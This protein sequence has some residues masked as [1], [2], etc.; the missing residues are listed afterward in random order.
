MS[1]CSVGE[2][3]GGS[4]GSVFSTG[5]RID[6][7]NS[8]SAQGFAINRCGNLQELSFPRSQLAESPP[9][10][11]LKSGTTSSAKQNP[12]RGDQ[13]RA[14]DGLLHKKGSAGSKFF[15]KNEHTKSEWVPG[16]PRGKGQG[17]EGLIGSQ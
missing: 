3:G 2:C 10:F 7:F 15:V 1:S 6:F 17:S 9:A 11:L 4:N 5:T 8:F 12:Q 13:S 14:V 16:R